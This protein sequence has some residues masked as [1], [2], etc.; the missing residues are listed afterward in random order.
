MTDSTPPQIVGVIFSA[1]DL[2]RAVRMRNPPDLFELRLDALVPD[3][4]SVKREIQKLRAPLIITARHPREGGVNQLAPGRRRALL[5]EFLPHAA[6][7]DIELRSGRASA[8]IL[9]AAR[10]Q[11]I[12]TIV[13]FHDFKGTPGAAKLTTIVRTAKSLGAD[14][15]KI[16]T[17]TDTAAQ[18]KTLLDFFEAHRGKMKLAAMG[19]GR[20]G[21]TA[22]L[23]CA[24][25]G[26]VLN[27]AHPGTPRVDG[28]LS[29]AQ[30]RRALK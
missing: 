23:W 8:A 2:K 13:S 21:R 14:L 16:A 9:K 30:W 12:R 3:L 15:V 25:H 26:S 27:Y 18:L 24:R 28:Q 6:Y 20:F 19:M 7:V 1:A 17:T 29:V 5:R 10:A 11:N 4:D 22:R